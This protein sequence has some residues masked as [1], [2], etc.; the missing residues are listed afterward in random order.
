MA[1]FELAADSGVHRISGVFEADL[2]EQLLGLHIETGLCFA[3]NST[4]AQIWRLLDPPTTLG[5]I[6]DTLLAEHD[7]D[8]QVCAR[9]V[10]ATLGELAR[11]GLV[12]FGR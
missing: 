9:D 11:D 8:P 1:P 10:K 7:V 6:C 12:R 5:A 3:M 4:A 2:G